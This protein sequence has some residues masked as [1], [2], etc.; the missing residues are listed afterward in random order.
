MHRKLNTVL[1][2][3]NR[4]LSQIERL[5]IAAERWNRAAARFP[6]G[7]PKFTQRHRD[8]IVELA[9]LK[10][11]LA[12][13]AFL[14]ESFVLY[15]WGKPPPRGAPPKCIYQPPRNRQLVEQLI[16][17]EGK[18]YVDWTNVNIVT[19]RAMRFFAGGE[20]YSR[21]LRPHQSFL[22]NMRFIRNAIAHSSTH[23]WDKFQR[24]VREEL[25]TAPP[26]LTIGGFLV[27][28]IPGSSPPE[29]FLEDYLYYL[30]FIAGQIVPS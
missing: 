28:T 2:S 16:V 26:H 9:F 12:W 7:V 19:T 4:R 5:T 11:F 21:T 15:V 10:A 3:L 20:P 13:E 18:D 17:P 22:D 14:E 8:M 6:W 24:L 30:K 25:R 23:S 27:T 1:A 29:S